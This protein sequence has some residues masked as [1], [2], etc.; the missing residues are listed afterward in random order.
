M[1][2]CDV[3][4]RDDIAYS[5]RLFCLSSSVAAVGFLKRCSHCARHRTT[6]RHRTMSS[7]VVRCRTMSC[8]VWTPLYPKSTLLAPLGRAVR[9]AW[10]CVSL[11]DSSRQQT[12]T[13]SYV[14]SSTLLVTKQ[15]TSGAGA[16]STLVP[17]QLPETDVLTAERYDGRAVVRVKSCPDDHVRHRL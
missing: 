5:M 17:E 14:E 11:T 7:G 4:L 9:W 12:E 16:W 13:S 6:Q 8:A 15:S 10:S 1:A 2:Q 3:T